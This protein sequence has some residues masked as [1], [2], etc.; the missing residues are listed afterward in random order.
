MATATN[1]PVTQ[2]LVQQAYAALGTGDPAV[3]RE[4]WDE[5]LQWLVPGQHQLAGLY[6]NLDEFLAFMGNVGRLS[7]GSFNMETLTITTNDEYSADVTHNTGRRAGDDPRT[8]DIN[9]IH[10]LRW[11]NGKV[12][13]GRG[14]IFGAGTEQFNA[15]WGAQ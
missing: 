12:I 7:G 10:L 1:A 15:F 6:R 9:V 8:L 4:Y 2:A 3:I 14:A 5:E 11:R 13:E